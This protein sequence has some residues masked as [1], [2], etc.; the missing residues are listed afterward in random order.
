LCRSRIIKTA[1]F[2]WIAPCALCSRN[3]HG[4][5]A[6]SARNTTVGQIRKQ[7]LKTVPATHVSRRPCGASFSV[8]QRRSLFLPEHRFYSSLHERRPVHASVHERRPINA[9]YRD[10]PELADRLFASLPYL[11]PFID[12]LGFAKYLFRQFPGVFSLVLSPLAP[13]IALYNI[14]F[15]SLGVYLALFILVVRNQSIDR[16]VR[17][18]A[19]QALFI[20]VLLII[21]GIA[22]TLRLSAVVP[23]FIGE[24]LSNA[25]FYTVLLTIVYSIGSCVSG[26]LPDQIPIVSD[27]VNS[28]IP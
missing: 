21:P 9:S 24:G 7:I 2:H 22:S 28:Q 12:S 25:V 14:P 11:L 3:T 18:N 20:D 19:M 26:K 27:S 4:F 10:E 6:Y 5:P 15:F 17:F 23:S 1:M 8:L 16:F 13:I